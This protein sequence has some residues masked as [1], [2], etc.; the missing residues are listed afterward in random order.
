MT[1][2]ANTEPLSAADKAFQTML[3]QASERQKTE[4]KSMLDG[5]MKD[6]EKKLGDSSRRTIDAF[7]DG[8]GT[9]YD[10]RTG[11]TFVNPSEKAGTGCA[12][13]FRALAQSRREHKAV[14]VVLQEWGDL[15]Q[16]N[17]LGTKTH[18]ARES[19]I[20]TREKALSAQNTTGA[21]ILIPEPMFAEITELLRARVVVES[22]GPRF[23]DMP[24]GNM[25]VGNEE[26]SMTATYGP[27]LGAIAPSQGSLGA[28]K[29]VAKKEVGLVGISNDLIR[30]APGDSANMFVRD[31]IVKTFAV[32][33]DLGLLRD[34]GSLDTMKGIRW[35]ALAANVVARSL[36]GSSNVT[37][38]TVNNDI[39]NCVSRLEQLNI[40][41]V[42]PVWF[43]SPR[44]K[45]FLMKLLNGLGIKI[46]G[47]EMAERGTLLGHPYFVTTNIPNT[48][49]A[50]GDESELYLID[51]DQMIV[52][53]A[54]SLEI[55]VSAD[56]SYTSSGGTQLNAFQR[57]E[58][59]IR[60]IAAHDCLFRYSGN[61]ITVVTALDWFTA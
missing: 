45:N 9:V 35:S 21:G 43:M 55:D 51:I 28:Q 36:N 41:M 20:A 2:S 60:A 13:M 44:T 54:R 37:L 32:R 22:A 10:S 8:A 61:E 29:L 57:D 50:G 19:F 33:K 40:P 16:K 11:K 52:G 4:L 18:E 6:V 14:D 7:R 31:Q 34:D 3:E 26:T 46:F 59:L 15:D 1:T 27:E 23:I 47:V 12:M 48:L 25:T 42:K 5:H 38:D 58:S 39:Q 56:G 30:Y 17:G 49:G 24:N 53:N